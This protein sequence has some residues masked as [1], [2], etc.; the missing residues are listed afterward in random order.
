MTNTE[1]WNKSHFL[2]T[3]PANPPT[4]TQRLNNLRSFEGTPSV[5][6]PGGATLTQGVRDFVF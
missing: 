2:P 1:A 6:H 3:Q 5:S 4:L